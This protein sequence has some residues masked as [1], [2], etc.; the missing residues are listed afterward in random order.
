MKMWG[1]RRRKPP[2]LPQNH[3]TRQ[4]KKPTLKKHK[5]PAF[6]SQKEDTEVTN[7]CGSY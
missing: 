6:L 1:K 4:N 3:N 2:Q 7:L 5:I